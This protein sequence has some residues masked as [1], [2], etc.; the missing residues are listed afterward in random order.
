MLDQLEADRLARVKEAEHRW[1][2]SAAQV[3]GWDPH[4]AQYELYAK[5]VAKTHAQ[6]SN[7]L[8][9]WQS[10]AVGGANTMAELWRRMKEEEKDPAYGA[11]LRKERQRLRDLAAE[12][13]DQARVDA[14]VT[15]RRA[16]YL[17]QR[18]AQQTRRTRRGG[19]K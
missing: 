10:T 2:C 16:E 9:P 3:T 11:Y 5:R 18:K 13:A 8:L 1:Y 7:I 17:L 12:A 19:P 4:E 6:L 14:E 15:K